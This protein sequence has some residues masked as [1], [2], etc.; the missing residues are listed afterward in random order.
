MRAKRSYEMAR[1]EDLRTALDN[2][3]VPP[4]T[5]AKAHSIYLSSRK[6]VS[7]SILSLVLEHRA[8]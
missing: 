6:N 7:E 8:T 2:K 3:K 5:K 1:D 4:G